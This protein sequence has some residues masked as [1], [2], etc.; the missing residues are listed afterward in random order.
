M[1]KKTIWSTQSKCKGFVLVLLCFYLEIWWQWQNNF[2]FVMATPLTSLSF[3]GST[4]DCLLDDPFK[5][6]WPQLPE[7]PGINYSMDEQCRF[8][9]GVGYK[10]CTSVSTKAKK[11][12]RNPAECFA[13]GTCCGW[14][15]R[16][17]ADFDRCAQMGQVIQ[18]IFSY[19]CFYCSL[20]M[21]TRLNWSNFFSPQ[22]KDK[23]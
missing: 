3:S 5:H 12:T 18:Q 11:W 6:D 2:K 10:I 14:W 23:M 8:D 21:D 20:L 15:Q 4:Y 17:S 22:R 19:I 1:V 13:G 16:C 9:F 7:L